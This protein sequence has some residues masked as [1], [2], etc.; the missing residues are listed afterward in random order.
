MLHLHCKRCIL[1]ER[2]IAEVCPEGQIVR[3]F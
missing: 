1:G 3:R 2:D